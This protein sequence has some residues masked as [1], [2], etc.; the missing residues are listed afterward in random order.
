MRKKYILR[1][2]KPCTKQRISIGY[3]NAKIIGRHSLTVCHINKGSSLLAHATT[4]YL[5]NN[6]TQ[7][8]STPVM[9]SSIVRVN[10]TLAN[11]LV[12]INA[13]TH[14]LHSICNINNLYTMDI[15]SILDHTIFLTLAT[16]QILTPTISIVNST[17]PLHRSRGDILNR[18]TRTLHQKTL[19]DA[20]TQRLL[21]KIVAVSSQMKRSKI[22]NIKHQL[23]T[24]KVKE[25]LKMKIKMDTFVNRASL[26][27]H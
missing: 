7:V 22:W 15:P 25:S 4:S 1:R 21:V 18:L 19:M 26:L 14:T 13:V 3:T 11:H 2:F 16:I 6:T 12:C 5:P 27:L 23:H 17:P 9:A 10:P 20:T 24:S 8:T